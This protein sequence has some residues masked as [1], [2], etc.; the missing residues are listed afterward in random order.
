MSLLPDI[1]PIHDPQVGYI[2]GIESDLADNNIE[3]RRWVSRARRTWSYQWAG[4]SQANAALIRDHYLAHQEYTAFHF[5]EFK[6]VQNAGPIWSSV[7][8]DETGTGALDTFTIP[9]KITTSVAVYVNDVLRTLT[10][11]YTLSSGTGTNGEDQIVFTEGNEPADEAIVTV[12]FAGRRRFYVKWA[13]P[14]AEVPAVYGTNLSGTLV[15][16]LQ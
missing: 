8:C 15:E 3:S 11:H 16:V 2:S 4:K 6:Y 5:F 12:N 1:T 9:G 7:E 10:T 14:L 13:A